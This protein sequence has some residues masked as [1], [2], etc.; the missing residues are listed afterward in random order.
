MLSLSSIAFSMLIKQTMFFL[1][2]LLSR[3]PFHSHKPHTGAERLIVDAAVELAERGH[4]VRERRERKEKE[5]EILFA[6]F[7]IVRKNTTSKDFSS[8][9]GHHARVTEE[10]ESNKQLTRE[11]MEHIQILN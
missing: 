5:E 3:S 7:S 8:S 6:M 1:T 9:L 11:R 4:D 10:I 2:R